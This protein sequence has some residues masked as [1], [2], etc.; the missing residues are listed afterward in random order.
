MSIAPPPFVAVTAF[1][2]IGWFNG[3]GDFGNGGGSGLLALLFAPSRFFVGERVGG[4]P[5]G[6]GGGIVKPGR[7]CC[8]PFAC[9]LG[10]KCSNPGGASPI[11]VRGLVNGEL[12]ALLLFKTFCAA[13][14]ALFASFA[15]RAFSSFSSRSKRACSRSL[16]I[17]ASSKRFSDILNAACRRISSSSSRW[18]R[19]SSSASHSLLTRGVSGSAEEAVGELLLLDSSRRSTEDDLPLLLLLLLLLFVFFFPL[20]F[21]EDSPLFPAC[22]VSAP[23]LLLLL[24]FSECFFLLLAVL[25]PFLL[26]LL[27]LPPNT[28]AYALLSLTNTLIERTI[29]SANNKSVPSANEIVGLSK[30]NT[31]FAGSFAIIHPAV[32]GDIAMVRRH[33]LN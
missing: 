8:V 28:F 21:F 14:S 13:F 10:D 16:S 1:R 9:A 4:S 17:A 23:L 32:N 11:A 15:N 29:S 7:G 22:C 19:S 27:V 24:F 31:N 6:T 20:A 26:F 12:D 2:F 33:T 5:G 25:L 3:G 18:R 30:S